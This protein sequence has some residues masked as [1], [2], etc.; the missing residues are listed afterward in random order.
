MKNHRA[1]SPRGAPALYY[2]GHRSL[3]RWTKPGSAHAVMPHQLDRVAVL[4][5]RVLAGD[6]FIDGHQDFLLANELEEMAQLHAL[7]LDHL[8][9][10]HG[11]RY[12]T[13]QVPFAFEG[14][15]LTHQRNGNHDRTVLLFSGDRRGLVP[16]DSMPVAI[17]NAWP[18]RRWI[19]RI[20]GCR[21]C[22][23]SCS[24]RLSARPISRH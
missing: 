19:S 15:E 8:A 18:C 22:N 24:C 4:N 16:V 1:G 9:D 10:G 14:L 20:Q 13:G 7:P 2:Y 12:F 23:S 3:H 17:D 5:Q 6:L 11:G 21:I